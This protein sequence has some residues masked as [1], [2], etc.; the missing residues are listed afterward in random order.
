MSIYKIVFSPTGGTQKVADTFAEALGKEN[1][2]VDL[3]DGSVNFG[4]ISFTEKD[5]CIV[6]VPSFGGRVPGIAISRLRQM[7]G[8][9]AYAVIIAV[10]GNR[11]YED[12][13]LELRN[14]LEQVGFRCVAAIA[15]IAEH[16]IMHQFAAGRPD[17]DDCKELTAFGEQVRHKMEMGNLPERLEVPGN[18]AY[19]EYGG[20]PMKPSADKACT[21]C[22]LC[23]EKCPVNAIPNAN[24]SKTDT[25]QCISCMRCIVVCPNKARSVSKILLTVGA[26]KIKKAC[27][28]CKKNEL[29][30]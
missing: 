26:Q 22:G 23:A 14:T 18:E 16:S 5:T 27:E 8:G 20:V 15:A 24:P 3:S 6:A 29:F 19:R 28:G 7:K 25:A 10:Y 11:A 12:T 1:A 30:L 2:F 9:N 17:A 13:L 4:Q 21:K